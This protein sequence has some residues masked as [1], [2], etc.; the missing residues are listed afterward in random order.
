METTAGN[1]PALYMFH[2]DGNFVKKQESFME[3]WTTHF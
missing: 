1:Q 2:L 3:N